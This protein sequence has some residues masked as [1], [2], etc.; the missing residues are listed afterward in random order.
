[1]VQEQQTSQGLNI[2]RNWWIQITAM[3]WS[4][5]AAPF[6]AI[7][8]VFLISNGIKPFEGIIEHEGER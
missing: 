2:L 4:L 8:S 5:E 6:Y 7:N 3:L 1:M